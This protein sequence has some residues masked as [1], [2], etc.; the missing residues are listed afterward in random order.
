MDEN[1]V[2]EGKQ[3]ND[4]AASATKAVITTDDIHK[5]MERMQK[6]KKS[7]QPL[8]NRIIRN[9][10]WWKQQHWDELQ[11]GE[12]K[13]EESTTGWLFNTLCNKHADIMD[14]YPEPS[15]LPRAKDDKETANIL[16]KIIPVILENCNYEAVYSDVGWYKLKQGTGVKGIFWNKSKLNGLG[17]IDIKK[18]DVLNVI[19]QP[20]INDI[21]E[22]SDIFTMEL[23]DNERLKAMYPDMKLEL[24][25]NETQIAKYQDAQDIDT[26][27]KSI[28]IDWYYK[29]VVNE[30]TLLHYVK[31]V[32]DTILYASE[33]DP[34]YAER[35]FY[36]HGLYPFVFDPLFPEENSPCGFG[37]IDAHRSCQKWIDKLDRNIAESSTLAS[38][39]RWFVA[40]GCSVNEDEYTDTSKTF[41]HVT[42]GRFDEDKFR[43]IKTQALPSV[44]VSVLK[45]KI[46]ELKET[47]GNRD[48]AQGGTASGVTAASAIAALMEA[49]SKMSRDQNKA[50]YRALV[51]EVQLIVE[52]IR[53]FYDTV[54]M[55]RITGKDNSVEYTAF[56][57]KNLVPQ[58]QGTV[59]GQDMGYRTPVFDVV[60]SAAK[61]STYSRLSQNE[62]ALQ[63]YNQGFFRPELASQALMC[64]EIMDFEGKEKIMQQI[65]ENKAIYDKERQLQMLMMQSQAMAAGMSIGRAVPPAGQQE[66]A[67]SQAEQASERARS[68]GEPQ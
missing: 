50:S 37:Y 60:I 28:V 68:T 18:I 64:L 21:Q 11:A 17:D 42:G 53:Q 67:G 38:K 48:F 65:R 33:N 55:F 62:L 2:P 3:I 34:E 44:Y 56:D 5:A 10:V 23:V 43:E 47:S 16:S 27:D 54:R 63:F 22:S 14:N 20:G 66:N 52:L 32:G 1:M 61:K 29:K 4:V 24:G 7:K 51:Q 25:G 13:E 6:Y 31:F 30:K 39:K 41:V 9:E 40:D 19:W 36:D 12:I 58:H 59:V 49:G 26:S 15:I 45:N 57:N 8:D 35:G 46:E